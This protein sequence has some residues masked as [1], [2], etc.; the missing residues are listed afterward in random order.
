LVNICPRRYVRVNHPARV[1]TD[2]G[3]KADLL[4][5]RPCVRAHAQGHGLLQSAPGHSLAQLVEER[6]PE[7]AAVGV[8]VQ[9][10]DDVLCLASRGT[11]ESDHGAFALER[12]GSLQALDKLALLPLV[13]AA[14]A[15]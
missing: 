4:L 13:G 5:R 11:S 15:F 6:L 8:G 3:E 1:W 12:A 10:Q 2:L 9:R 7:L 14:S